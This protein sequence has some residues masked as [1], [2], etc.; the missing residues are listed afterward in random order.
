VIYPLKAVIPVAAFLLLLQGLSEFLK[1][2]YA[3]RTGEWLTKHRSVE[4][5]LSEGITTHEP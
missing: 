1:C 2:I 3:L 5:A 4:E